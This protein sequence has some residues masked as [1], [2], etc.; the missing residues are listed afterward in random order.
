M[1]RIAGLF[2]IFAATVSLVTAALRGAVF[3][4]STPS[5]SSTPVPFPINPPPGWTASN[6]AKTRVICEQI[7][8]KVD[9][10]R[11]LSR[12]EWSE[13]EGCR[14]I[15]E[16][17]QEQ[18]EHSPPSAMRPAMSPLPTPGPPQEA[19]SAGPLAA[20]VSLE[21][22]ADVAGLPGACTSPTSQVT[23]G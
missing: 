5:P 23:V 2:C 17:G 6:W 21:L 8:A 16:W 20:A 3:A 11:P 12:R 4:Q 14:S 22:A 9:A 18:R 15:L 7:R 1:K 19:S 13:A 10:S